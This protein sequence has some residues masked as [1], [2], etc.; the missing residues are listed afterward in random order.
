MA[1]REDRLK[2]DH[3][4]LQRL[5]VVISDVKIEIIEGSLPPERYRLRISNCK[6]VES[7][8]N[9]SPK[10]RTEHVLVIFN[11]PK[12]YPDPGELP[13]VRFETPIYHPNVY[14]FGK[15]CFE[16]REV[17]TINQPLDV[18]VKRVI[19]MI[20]YENLRFGRPAN[21]EANVWANKN[22]HLFPLSSNSADNQQP[23][24]NWR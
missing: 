2:N 12:D 9:G 13:E 11:F 21:S 10:Y 14:S 1:T 23:T 4:A 18:L 24:I 15:V 7:V 20:Q 5:C 3:K 22:Q 19:S 17:K 8:I 16:G 6:A